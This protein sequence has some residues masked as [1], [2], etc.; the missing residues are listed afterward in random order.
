[1]H[2]LAKFKCLTIT[3]HHTQPGSYFAEVRLVPVW[4]ENGRNREW[5]QA[6]PAGELKMSITNEAAA[7]A[8]EIGVEYDLTFEP[9]AK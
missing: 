2:V 9:S 7:E 5:S 4:E 1:M 8:F 6:T 3:R